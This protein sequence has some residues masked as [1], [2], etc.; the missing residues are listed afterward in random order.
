MMS[1]KT[2][3]A[4]AR[5]EMLLNVPEEDIQFAVRSTLERAR[6][7]YALRGRKILSIDLQ[8]HLDFFDAATMFDCV[9]ESAVP[10]GKRVN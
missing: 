4:K 9:D 5:E 7:W 10:V 2:A 1:E 8:T 3:A 6:D